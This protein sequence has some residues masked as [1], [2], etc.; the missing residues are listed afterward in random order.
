MSPEQIVIKQEIERS[1]EWLEM[2]Q[3][4]T[5]FLAVVLAARIVKQNEHIEYLERRLDHVSR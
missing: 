5:A 4:P 1:F 2:A 3:D